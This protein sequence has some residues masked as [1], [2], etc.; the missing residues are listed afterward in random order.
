MLFTTQFSKYS[1]Y[2]EQIIGK[3]RN[4]G[5]FFLIVHTMYVKRGMYLFCIQIRCSCDYFKT[6]TMHKYTTLNVKC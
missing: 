5:V 3:N 4:I 1:H 2:V 6:N